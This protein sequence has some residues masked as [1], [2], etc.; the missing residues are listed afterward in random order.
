MEGG[1]E[2]VEE[3]AV[4]VVGISGGRRC[5]PIREVGGGDKIRTQVRVICG[6]ELR[7][8]AHSP[9]VLMLNSFI[10]SISNSLFDLHETIRL[11]QRADVEEDVVAEEGEVAGV[12]V[13]VETITRT[14]CS[15]VLRLLRSLKVKT[16]G[17]QRRMFLATW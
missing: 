15:M 2:V 6:L 12:G 11:H 4:V 14:T 17:C 5:C 8:V 9:W 16:A 13:D 10:F 7:Y 3:E 1:E